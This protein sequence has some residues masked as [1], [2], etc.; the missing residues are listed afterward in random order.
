MRQGGWVFLT[1]WTMLPA[2]PASPA[3]RPDPRAVEAVVQEA[4]HSRRDPQAP[5][6]RQRAL[7]EAE[8]NLV[9]ATGISDP[10]R[11]D[12]LHRLADL[13]MRIESRRGEP[14]LTEYRNR[15][16]RYRSG[17]LP[18]RPLPP[19]ILHPKSL[20]IYLRLLEASPRRPGNDRVLYQVARARYEEGNPGAAIEALRRLA[21]EYPRSPHLA[22]ARFRL[23]D[24][25][26]EQ[27]A[28]GEAAE[29]YRLGIQQEEPGASDLVR[30]KLGW[31]LLEMQDLD[32]AITA[33]LPLLDRRV[34]AGPD[35]Q[36]ELVLYFLPE[37]EADLLREVT[38]RI[39]EAFDRKGGPAALPPFFRAHPRPYEAYLYQKMAE[40][41]ETE[42]RPRDA[43]AALERL[44]EARPLDPG[45]PAILQ[46]TID[47]LTRSGRIGEAMR[48]RER[49]VAMLD[50]GGEWSAGNPR[51]RPV[52]RAALRNALR[53]LALF[54]HEQS[55][56]SQTD[57]RR[58]T[59]GDLDAAIDD[60]RRFLEEFPRDPEAPRFAFLLGE[61]YFAEARFAE[62]ITAY[63]SSLAA[64]PHPDRV[65][66][67]F[68]AAVAAQWRALNPRDVEPKASNTKERFVAAT[69]RFARIAPEDPR[70]ADLLVAAAEIA[71]AADPDRAVS[72][73]AEAARMNPELEYTMEKFIGTL[74][75]Q[76]GRNAAAAE[77][78]R[79]AAAKAPESDRP[80]VR[81][82]LA[83][84]LYRSGVELRDRDP[85]S[86]ARQ[87]AAI[88]QEAPGTEPALSGLVD[89]GAAYLEAGDA[90]AAT[91][92]WR[93]LLSLA[94]RTP[95]RHRI[96][97]EL[98][99]IA[100]Q[101]GDRATAIQAY[102]EIFGEPETPAAAAEAA[103]RLGMLAEQ[104]EI[105]RDAD[106]WF[107]A[108]RTRRDDPAGAAEAGLHQA[109]AKSHLGQE[110]AAQKMLEEVARGAG[111]PVLSFEGTDGTR[112]R[113]A[114]AR[115]WLALG[116][117]KA[118]RFEAVALRAPLERTLAEKQRRLE[119]A[120]RAFGRASRYGIT[121]VVTAATFHL[122]RLYESMYRALIEAEP[123]RGLTAEQRDAYR[124]LVAQEAAPLAERARQAYGQNADA[125]VRQG[126]TDQWT[127]R[128]VEA[129]ARLEAR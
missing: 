109:I 63:E 62:A 21:R 114:V 43:I 86:A 104:A 60:Y 10:I 127:Q 24:L 124:R 14:A 57:S 53:D 49:L 52:A 56:R 80:A 26:F 76:K 38:G 71:G 17:Q 59:K 96:R 3:Y 128:S 47:L 2:G 122:G 111:E 15:L 72:L 23:G 39:L 126:Y 70:A 12:A 44:L 99:R 129:L 97:R 54:H 61:A 82:L 100:E 85:A 95:H 29:A 84:A 101:G 83:T 116:E 125:A 51:D 32:G 74:L 69:E 90:S 28:Y 7:E 79:Q 93:R 73:A 36:P 106:R 65:E 75:L 18:Q 6:L 42:G 78:L 87:L 113:E 5:L 117:M 25:R 98:A 105:W 34:R 31:S 67:A 108:A 45:A 115:A 27:R 33:F 64:G 58:A 8:Q 46:R 91:T 48:A 119:E 11:A 66:A 9:E 103:L 35:G 88:E 50:P 123:P 13:Y 41:Y 112:R 20:P 92:A 4:L 121:D 22:E 16:P 77:A 30:Y 110:T 55:A 120:A 37:A 40:R 68:G 94:P 19:R 107:G 102:T 81:T 1:L 118:R 89:A